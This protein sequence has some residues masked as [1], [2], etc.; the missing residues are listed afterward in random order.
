M[1][2]KT[3]GAK[4]KRHVGAAEPAAAGSAA[5][6]RPG[7]GARSEVIAACV[8]YGGRVVEPEYSKGVSSTMLQ[9]VFGESISG[10]KKLGVLVRAALNETK[11]D[12]AAAGRET[13]IAAETLQ[14][15]IDGSE[16][17]GLSID[18][19]A[20]LLHRTYPVPKRHLM[21]DEDNS[22][23]GAWFMTSADSQA[24]ARVFDRLNAN[25]ATVPYYRYM[26]TS[27]TSLSPFK[28]E[29]IEELVGVEDNEPL[30]PLVVMNKGH[31]LGQLT[32]FIG[33]VNFYYTVRGVRRCK[34]MNTGDSCLI[35]PY[36][37]HS[38]TSRDLGQYAAIVAVTFSGHVREVLQDLLHLDARALCKYAADLRAPASVLSA[39]I[40]RAAELRG[41]SG[42]ALH[43]ELVSKGQDAEV[44][45]AALSGSACPAEPRAAATL[46]AALAEAL[47]VDEGEFNVRPLLEDEEVTFS[48]PPAGGLGKHAFAGSAHMADVGG[49]HW[50][51]VGSSAPE[52]SRFYQYVYNCGSVPAT[53][54]WGVE[55]AAEEANVRVLAPGDSVTFKPFIQVGYEVPEGGAAATLAIFKCAG[56]VNRA[57]MHEVALFEPKG[58]TSIASELGMWY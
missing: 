38:F 41:V 7:L 40:S 39:R 42:Q 21:V 24:T 17:D 22:D 3:A 33:P 16:H 14:R 9:S 47:A 52:G 37:P 49:Y 48:P 18:S 15:L 6:L 30:N 20:R 35:T 19:L 50:S 25:G 46:A 45:A 57:V 43:A 4:R 36:V 11:R 53:V 34:P 55:G 26:D 12:V 51:L 44:A 5:A 8:E 31:L 1:Q 28:P 32:Y 29:L 56:C 58:M 27:A 13:G 10:A 23:G 2:K 54:R